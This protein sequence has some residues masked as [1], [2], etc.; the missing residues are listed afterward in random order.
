LILLLIV[1]VR[2]PYQCK[3][4]PGGPS[5]ECVERHVKPCSLTDT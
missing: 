1:V 4:L 5:L 3:W 2:T